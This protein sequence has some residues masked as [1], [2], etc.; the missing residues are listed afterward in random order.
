MT[1]RP[2][3]LTTRLLLALALLSAVAPFATDLYLPAFPAMATDLGTDAT[4]IQLTL[5]AFLVGMAAGQLIFGPLSDR[6][7]RR[8]PL[9]VGAVVFVL[10]S[11]V[12][13]FAPTIGVLVAARLVQGLAGSAGMVLGRAIISDLA[14]GEVAARAF[15][16]M[17]IVGGV[18]PVVA[19]VAGSLLTEALGWRGTLGVLTG[20][21]VLMLLAVLV[22]VPE[23]L[24]AHARR[25]RR[26]T[27]SPALA[28][29]VADV[30]AWGSP[31][32]GAI[33]NGRAVEP[34]LPLWRNRTYLL[35]TAVFVA[36]FAVMMAYISASPFVYQELIG[37]SAVTYGLVFGANALALMATSAV[38]SKLLPSLGSRRVM[39]MGLAGLGVGIVLLAATAAWLPVALLPIPILLTVASLGFILGTATA[40]ALDAVRGPAGVASAVLGAAQFA[41]AGLVS[42]LVGLGGGVSATPM[43]LVMAVAGAIAIGSGVLYAVGSR[44]R[45][46]VGDADAADRSAAVDAADAEPGELTLAGEGAQA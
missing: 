18:A 35:C 31:A 27:A 44:G 15:T 2:H 8:V 5:T 9:V 25:G 33:V 24:P 30:P 32:S 17:M 37:L 43:V 7:G 16:L 10:S 29:D 41:A 3:L 40:L 46:D 28:A 23:T 21:A 36:S 14:R 39:A 1:S 34:T 42:P 6:L 4:A 11:L 20:I 13:A 12:V 22:A 38:A 26:T 19:P 45:A